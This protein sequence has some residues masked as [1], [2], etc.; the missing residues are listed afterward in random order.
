[1]CL[2][3]SVLL[4]VS[5]SAIAAD[6]VLHVT[7]RGTPDGNGTLAR[8][9]ATIMQAVALARTTGV[10]RIEVAPGNYYDSAVTLDARDAGLTI[11][12][13]AHA[14]AILYGGIAPEKWHREGDLFVCSQPFPG[15]DPVRLL[16]VNG[17][18]AERARYPETGFLTH[19]SNFPVKWLSTT[20]GGW[21]R[22][23]TD[24]ELLR[25]K[26]KPEDIPATF[27]AANAE[28]TIYHMWDES[29]VQVASIDRENHLLHLA[30]KPGHPAGAFNVKRYVLWNTAEGMTKPGQFYHDR[31]K[32][33]LLYRPRQGEKVDAIRT[34]VGTRA[35]ILQIKGTKEQPAK[36][37]T[38]T[39]LSF[40]ATTIPMKAGGFGALGYPGAV[41]IEHTANI[42]LEKLRVQNVGGQGI[43]S[44]WNPSSNVLIEGCEVSH[45]GA[46]GI[47]VGGQKNIIRGNHIHDIGLYFPSGLGIARGSSDSL[48]E[49]NNIH[50]CSY[51]GIQSSGNRNIIRNNEL[52]RCMT[53]L[54][55]GAAIYL[56]MGKESIVEGNICR[57]I[58]GTGGYARAGYYLDEQC[59]NSAVQHNIAI[60][61]DVPLHNHMARSCRLINNVMVNDGDMK[62][63][64]A[65]CEDFMMAGNIAW[66]G[67]KLEVTWANAYSIW[68]KNIFFSKTNN[69]VFTAV[70]E[71]K[72]TIPFQTPKGVE[73]VD[74][75]FVNVAKRD[76][77]FAPK[78]PA[79]TMGLIELTLPKPTTK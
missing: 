26:Y 1:M 21:E 9:C 42:R 11:A 58:G 27:S 39:G 23:P 25:V 29:C 49:G 34:V 76:L 46:G 16:I 31:E 37:I 50:D 13:P 79:Q 6:G 70:D 22:K 63:A 33:R 48:I 30:T 59:E 51:S 55:D 3:S 77:R 75:L 73:L 41:S 36:D 62:L 67:G 61:V 60:N 5:S 54:F 18:L 52:A 35:T 12:G 68:E 71:N 32:G 74:P 72:K 45:C 15:K 69:V 10:R 20:A 53:V 44:T 2:L 64:A 47:T 24:E 78:S 43:D 17:K 66:A 8:P 57:D 7:P 4:L 38:I 65:R 19:E 14:E 40:Q 56:S 28:I